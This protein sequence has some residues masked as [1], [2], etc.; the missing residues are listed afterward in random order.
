MKVLKSLSILSGVGV[1]ALSMA[2]ATAR[3]EQAQ[4]S[5]AKAQTQPRTTAR[6]TTARTNAR[7]NY[8]AYSYEPSRGGDVAPRVGSPTYTRA[9]SKVKFR[10]GSYP[11]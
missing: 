7:R 3:A 4:S 11:Y 9:D 10:Y 8:R 5:T 1:V 6:T 2:F